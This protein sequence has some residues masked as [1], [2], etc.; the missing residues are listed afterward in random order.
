MMSLA[1]DDCW[2]GDGRV[3]SGARALAEATSALFGLVG[4]NGV[5]FIVRDGVPV[6][7]EVNPRWS[8]SMELVDRAC[9]L[10]VMAAHVESCLSD[11]VP[12]VERRS[13]NGV[14]GKA[15]VFATAD[16]TVGDT[17]RWLERDEVRDVPWPG[18]SIGC[19]EPIC[20]VFATAPTFVEC[21]AALATNAAAIY[22]EVN[23]CS[24]LKPVR[25][26]CIQAVTPGSRL[27][28]PRRR[29]QIDARLCSGDSAPGNS[30]W[31]LRD[32]WRRDR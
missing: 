11:V 9:D 32:W 3:A 19:G 24:S 2:D 31:I 13:G 23:Q 28:R 21:R 14:V 30:S 27:A 5:D 10:P 7:I 16:V 12:R 6:A 29:K 4:V 15:V 17:R 18:T 1:V 25:R 8:A 26:A 22:A 20:T